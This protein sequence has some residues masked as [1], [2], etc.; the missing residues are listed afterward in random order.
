[1]IA[2]TQNVPA[3]LPENPL[4]SPSIIQAGQNNTNI[5]RVEN[6]FAPTIILTPN[7]PAASQPNTILPLDTSCYHLFVI[8]GE[9]F[10][11]GQLLINPRRALTECVS[12]EI[13][14]RFQHLQPHTH[15]Q[16]QKYPALF[17]SEN[18][19]PGKASSDQQA[20]LGFITE[21]RVQ[22]NGIRIGYQTYNIP[23][24]QQS[25]NENADKLGIVVR[26][27][28]SELDRTHWTLKRVNLFEAFNDAGINFL[29]FGCLQTAASLRANGEKP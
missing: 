3:A 4:A 28:M 13:K 29:P 25:L 2:V 27:R 8:A 26:G 7:A 19:K 18:N 16:L 1:M 10:S 12:E 5:A 20:F 9:D 24:S 22:D 15:K 17:M 14:K 21:I 23:I 6:A 11:T